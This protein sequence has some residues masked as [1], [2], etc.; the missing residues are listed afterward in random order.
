MLHPSLKSFNHTP[1]QKYHAEALLKSKFEK[2][3]QL[4]QQ[5]PLSNN[6]RKKQ[7]QE[8]KPTQL[9]ISLDD[10]F[11]LPTLPDELLYNIEQKAEFDK[12]R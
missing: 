11:D 4:E 5:Q 7:I 2:N 8:N 12:Y 1:S 9:S 6:N 10:I 3:H